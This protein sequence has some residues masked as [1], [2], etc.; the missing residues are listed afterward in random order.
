MGINLCIEKI[1]SM[2]LCSSS[3]ESCTMT[4]KMPDNTV[5]YV[6]G[7]YRPHSGSIQDFIDVLE[8][9]FEEIP[10]I[11]GNR[12]IVTGD[13]NINLLLQKTKLL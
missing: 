13:L 8:V 7:I 1:T 2:S 9:L 4:V 11:A 3:I 6:I 5:Y 10:N 12:V